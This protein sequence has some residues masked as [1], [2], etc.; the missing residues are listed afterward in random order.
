MSRSNAHAISA[1]CAT[2]AHFLHAHS[3]SLS[4]ALILTLGTE[5]EKCVFCLSPPSVSLAIEE[6]IEWEK[7]FYFC[8]A[9]R[10]IEAIL[11]GGERNRDNVVEFTRVDIKV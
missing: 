2:V 6:A 3:L 8:R 4:I 11:R 9:V 1:R 7:I 5:I 10:K